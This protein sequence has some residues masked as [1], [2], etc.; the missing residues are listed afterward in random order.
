MDLIEIRSVERF[1]FVGI[2]GRSRIDLTRTLNRGNGR[3]YRALSP[4]RKREV[5]D[6]ITIRDSPTTH[7]ITL[8]GGY[9]HNQTGSVDLVKPIELERE[10]RLAELDAQN[11]TLRRHRTE[12]PKFFGP[13]AVPDGQNASSVHYRCR[14]E[15]IRLDGMGT[16]TAFMVHVGAGSDRL[17]RPRFSKALML[18]DAAGGFDFFFVLTWS[19]MFGAPIKEGEL[20]RLTKRKAG[21]QRVLYVQKAKA[22]A[23]T[24]LS[25]STTS[26][27]DRLPS[28]DVKRDPQVWAGWRTDT[29]L[30]LAK[31]AL[32]GDQNHPIIADALQDA[33]CDDESILNH[34]RHPNIH[35]S[36]DCWAVR[37]IL[38]QTP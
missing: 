17:E 24:L 22:D 28:D 12:L 11:P 36:V 6:T 1:G 21:D 9:S 18:P 37:T 10:K 7:E 27:L 3:R 8:V 5:P 29:V 20:S 35:H 2:Q 32:V 14:G 4:A 13:F 26:Y 23:T 33:G 19:D 30:G 31:Q 34:L 16:G 38:G 15:D 25:A